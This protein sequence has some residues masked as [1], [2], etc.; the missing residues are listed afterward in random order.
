MKDKKEKL[1]RGY[2]TGVHTSFAF[3]RALECFLV[4][5]SLSIVKTIKMDN[6]DLDV[7][8]GCEI[9][10]CISNNKKDLQINEIEH[11]PYLLYNKNNII[12]IYSG[13]GVGIVTKDGL[14]PP[15][16]YPA[17]N[18]KPLDV[19]KEIYSKSK[20][21]YKNLFC[22]IGVVDGLKIAKQT[23]NA[24]V[25]VLGGISILGTSGFVKPISAS[26]YINSIKEEL[27]YARA[28][29]YK[30]IIFTLGNTAFKKA[31]SLYKDDYIIEIGNF[32][33]DGISLAVD[34][35]FEDIVLMLGV[36]KLVKVSQ[37]FK[38]THNRFGS[39]DFSLVQQ[40]CDTDIKGC[41]TIKR[42]REILDKELDKFDNIILNQ[43]KEQLYK[44]FNKE[45]KV[46]VC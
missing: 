38:N 34:L 25:G 23:A 17:I 44:W 11:K 29:D 3:Q 10:V 28:N 26:A 8:K 45:I 46:E 32:I 4:S 33:Y 20:I 14:K 42:V 16:G 35:Q 21:N 30:T 27:N 39:I 19:L 24:K 37:G 9:I 15:K 31:N 12:E 1:K 18:P 2:T 43:S 5:S 36:G 13:N 7:T 41:L 6:D 40:L 22:T